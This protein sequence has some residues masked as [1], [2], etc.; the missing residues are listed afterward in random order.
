MEARVAV[1]KEIACNTEKL[2]DRM[3]ARLIRIEDG[4]KLDFRVLFTA[5]IATTLGLAA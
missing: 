4:Q 2:L 5:L 3:D 1:L